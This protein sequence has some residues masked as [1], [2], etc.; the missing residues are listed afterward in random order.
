MATP[1]PIV[2]GVDLRDSGDEALRQAAAW[3]EREERPL[4]VVHATGDPVSLGPLFRQMGR[5]GESAFAEIEQNARAEV[6][7]RVAAVLGDEALAQIIIG[8]GSP[9]SVILDH[10]TRAHAR[11]TV[12]GAT[13]ASAIGRLLLGS[14]AE[15]VV[16]HSDTWVL[17]AQ[18]S[19]ASKVVLVASDLSESA[20]SAIE[21]AHEEAIRRKARLVAVHCLDLAHPVIAAFE[22]GVTVDE[23]TKA[24][25]RAAA[26]ET[27]EAQLSRAGASADIVIAD[28]PPARAVLRTAEEHAA[29]L[30]V[31]STHGRTGLARVALGSVASAVASRASCAV[32]VV[33]G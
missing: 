30:L 6:E 1:R 21:A 5:S 10:A 28:G 17:V 7:K 13:E 32:L 23:Q 20:M 22:P 27:L 15:Q 19:P 16:R 2:V 29:G 11:L 18:P 9:H 26:R 25:L 4:I 14:T 3:A 8:Q 33:R 12:V 24:A 31:V